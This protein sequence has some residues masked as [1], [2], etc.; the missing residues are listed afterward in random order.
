MRIQKGLDITRE[1]WQV[2]RKDRELLVFPLCSAMAAALIVGTIVSAGL[3]IPNF[4]QW[5]TGMLDDERAHT[6]GEHAL[7]IVCLFVIYL[8]EWSVVIYF[9]TALE[10]DKELNLNN[11]RQVA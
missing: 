8:L 10:A 1:S 7:G 11:I 3:L 4:G 6:V 9:N 2:L 5:A